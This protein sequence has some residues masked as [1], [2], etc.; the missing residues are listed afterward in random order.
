MKSPITIAPIPDQTDTEGDTIPTLSVNGGSSVTYSALGL[1]PGLQIDPS[2]GDITG[3]L[4]KGAAMNGPYSV[5]VMAEDGTYSSE[6][7][8]GVRNLHGP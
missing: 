7:R 5:T 1:P 3:T 2:S 4:A 6:L 8:A